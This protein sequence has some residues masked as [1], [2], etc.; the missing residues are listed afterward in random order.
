LRIT[1]LELAQIDPV[2][3][4]ATRCI[5]AMQARRLLA[6]FG[7]LAGHKGPAAG[8]HAPLWLVELEALL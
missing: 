1:R 3:K 6:H 4:Q 7:I 2:A 8:H 5:V